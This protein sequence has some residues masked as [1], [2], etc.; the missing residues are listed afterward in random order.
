M[1]I[2]TPSS[3]LPSILS[4]SK[5]QQQIHHSNSS[6]SQDYHHHH[7][8]I[9]S[10]PNGFERSAAATTMT[11]QDPHQQ[12]IRRDKVRV[13]GFEPPPSHQTLVPIE[14]DESGS[15]PVYE[16]AGMLSEMFN[17]TPGAT[18][19]L[20]QQQQQQQP[21]ATT[22]ARAVGSGGSEWYGNRQGMLSNLGPLGD[23]KNHHH[24]GSVNS[25]DSSSSSIVQN[26][27]HHHHNHHHH[28][29]SSINADSAAA[30]QLF[31]MNPQTTRSPSPPPPPPPSSSTLHMLLPNT[32]PP[33]SGGSF[34][35]FT[36]LPDTTQE[37]GP[38]TVV[39]GPGHGHGQGLSLSLSSSIE[40][41]KAEE[42]RMGDSGFLYYNQASGG[43]SSYKSTLG[44][45]H[46]QALLGQAHQ[47]NV[48]F[49][50][51]SSSTSSLG[52]VNALR[53]S[54]YA[55][56][57]QELLEEFCSVGRGQ[58]K[59]NKF[60]RQLSNP[61]S[62]LGGSGGGGGGASSSSSKDIPPL[63]A[64]DRIE[65]QR[66][67]VKLL[68]MLD[69]VD[70][71]YSH[72]CEQMHMVVNSFD[73]VMGFGAAVPYTA[74]AQKAMSR[75]FRCLKDAITAQLKH[76]CEVLGE[77][78][79]AGNSG[80]TKGETPR[81]KML[82]QSLRQQRAFHQMGMME[83]EA[84]RPQRGLPERSVNILRA[85]LFEHFL[86]PYP[87]DADKHL[88]AR[89]TGLSRNQ[90]S[91]WFINARVR[92]WKPMVEDM[93]QQEL[94]EAEGAEEDRERNQSSSNN[95]GH[96][97]AQTPT[98]STTA[99]TATAPPPTTTTPPNGKRSDTE[100]DPSLAQINN[101]TSTTV[102]T[103]TA[104]QVTP[105]SELPRTMVADESCRHG[106]LVATD[107]G[108]A[109]A[110]SDIGS[111]LIRFG[112]TTGD[113]SLTLGLRH[114]GNMPEKTPFS[115]RDFGGI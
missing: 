17:F 78:D 86:H 56:A 37:G 75:H 77:K 19:L 96:Q 38:S 108:T 25:R 88:L 91:N 16:T 100:S 113:V 74:L 103:V 92:L 23:S 68:T 69:E 90:V 60:N 107:F 44:G 1:G 41:A 97:L 50:A 95:S 10:F 5:T 83:Q 9:F 101:T 51:A 73:M 76:S 32:F 3:S 89:Q 35:Q 46:H 43:P 111:T 105:P 22:T 102:M 79:G 84:W 85:W 99:S 33:G 48:G 52:V 47:G 81:L 67:K 20:E 104:T 64:A 8:G 70:R 27:H 30:M 14:E 4:H 11:H 65:H 57:A 98:P 21:M 49:G 15:L 12:Q 54:K 109:S 53:N 114:A 7:Q 94:K 58:F 18:E 36:W 13:Q 39:E 115:V 106:S 28:Q 62:N 112:T 59:K 42:L 66:R 29:M 71:R 6:M 40:A 93:Y 61:S 72:Y 31:L 63:S 26:Q 34:G 2:A 87:S 82:E 55:K 110:A 45:H 80:L 24:H